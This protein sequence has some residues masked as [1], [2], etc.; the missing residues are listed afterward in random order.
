LKDYDKEFEYYSLAFPNWKVEDAFESLKE[1][2][3]R[4]HFSQTRNIERW[5]IE[6]A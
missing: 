1:L 4:P 2:N 3:N 6:E 5:V